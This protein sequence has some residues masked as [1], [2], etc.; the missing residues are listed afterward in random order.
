MKS[1]LF[2]VLS[3][4]ALSAQSNAPLIIG[5]DGKYLGRLSS[6][7]WDS[8]S[9]SNPWGKYGN[10]WS[11]DSINNTWGKYGNPWSSY[12]TGG[13][14]TVP[15][16]PSGGWNVPSVSFPDSSYLS[17]GWQPAPSNTVYVPVYVPAAPVT[18]PPRPHKLKKSDRRAFPRDSSWRWVDLP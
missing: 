14:V 18:P 16:A 2:T 13:P 7:T 3:A 10:P 11:S 8:D 6:N 15:S 9:V 17:R 5:A 1:F 4:L 12:S